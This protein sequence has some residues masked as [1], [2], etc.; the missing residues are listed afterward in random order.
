MLLLDLSHAWKK[1]QN[2]AFSEN[3][4]NTRSGGDVPDLKEGIGVHS[5]ITKGWFPQLCLV[6]EQLENYGMDSASPT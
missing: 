1:G 4:T 6:V 5:D 3:E 2:K